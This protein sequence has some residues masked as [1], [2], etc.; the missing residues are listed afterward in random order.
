MDDLSGSGFVADKNVVIHISTPFLRRGPNCN[1]I[2]DGVIRIQVDDCGRAYKE[3]G[4]SDHR[5]DAFEDTRRQRE[6]ATLL[7]TY[8]STLVSRYE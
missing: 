6:T 5:Y 7:R 2:G 1:S 3:L 4:Y 8:L